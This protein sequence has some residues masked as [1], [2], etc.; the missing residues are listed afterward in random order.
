MF[1][2]GGRCDGQWLRLGCLFRGADVT[3]GGCV[4]GVCFGGQNVTVGGCVWG[5]CFGGQV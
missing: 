1:V 5:V 2:S 3:V 4:W